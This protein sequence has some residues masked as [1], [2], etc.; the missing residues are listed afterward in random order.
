MN[1]MQLGHTLRHHLTAAMLENVIH[2][3]VLPEPKKEKTHPILTPADK[4]R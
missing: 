4:T 1:L 3:R 2:I